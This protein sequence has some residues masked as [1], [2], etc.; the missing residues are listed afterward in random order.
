VIGYWYVITTDRPHEVVS[1]GAH[2]G[3]HELVV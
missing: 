3:G 1:L 2:V